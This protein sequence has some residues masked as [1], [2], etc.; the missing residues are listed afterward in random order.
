MDRRARRLQRLLSVLGAPSR[1][2]IVRVLERRPHHVSEL[3]LVIGLSQSCTTRHLQAMRRLGIVQTRRLGKR[4]M[5]EL[6]P[7]TAEAE[8]LIAWLTSAGPPLSPASPP[9]GGQERAPATRRRAAPAAEM[10]IAEVQAHAP[11]PDSAKAGSDESPAHEVPV[12]PWSD[13]EDFLL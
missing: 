3:A 1:F 2:E 13:I 8:G 7:E 5:A 6:T 11:V 12:A 9:S 10:A 4:V